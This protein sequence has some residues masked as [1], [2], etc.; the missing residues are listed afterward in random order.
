MNF[1]ISQNY[2]SFAE[3]AMLILFGCSWPFNIIKSYKSRTAKGKSV[4][5][6]FV[7]LLAYAIGV[8][9]KFVQLKLTGTLPFA[10][11]IYFLDIIMVSIDVA[12]YFRNTR[13]DKQRDI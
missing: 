11:W 7:I 10:T 4:Q 2:I 5:F 1:F 9:G 3:T 13:I 6:E 12:L 8:S